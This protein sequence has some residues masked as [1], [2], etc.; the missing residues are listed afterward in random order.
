[1]KEAA[2]F[3]AH[4]ARNKQRVAI[5]CHANADPDGVASSVVLAE[6][7]TSLGADAKA[8][9]AED[10]S[11]VSQNLLRSFGRDIGIDPKL[12][13][14]LAVLVDTSSLEHLGKFGKK[15]RYYDA[16]LAVID[17][18]KPVQEM[19]Q[20]TSLY[21]VREDFP[22]ESELIFKVLAELNA[23]L[24]PDQASL[25]LAGVISDTGYFRLAKPVTFEV[26]DALLKSGADYDRVIEILRPPDD[27]SRRVA[28]LKAAGRSEMLQF[29]GRLVVFSELGSFE[30][31]AANMLVRIGADAAFVG[32]INK[33]EF[34]ISGR[35]KPEFVKKTGLHLGELMEFLGKHFD[36]NGGGHAGA[37]SV[38]GKGCL[39]QGKKQLLKLLKQQ[40]AHE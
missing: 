23:N 4:A 12:E 39:D 15:L 3:L 21:L 29:S 32:S 27:I 17:H 38:N 26:V 35:A 1:M 6:I 16:K 8:A 25:L 31:D 36:G 28:M 22:S 2:D 18:H 20:L 34:R 5:L 7:M 30:G 33:N 10:L 40:L 37:A 14:D 24:T 9:A 19:K 11:S 13:F